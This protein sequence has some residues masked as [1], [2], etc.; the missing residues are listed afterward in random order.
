MSPDELFAAFENLFTA[1][2]REEAQDPDVVA[3]KSAICYRT[4]L[5]VDPAIARA[6]A[7]LSLSCLR[8]LKG[9]N[10]SVR[11]QHKSLNDWI[12][13]KTAQAAA[14]AEIP[15]MNANS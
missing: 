7:V 2:L 1:H 13:V 14:Q 9:P 12:V 3:F 10:D 4:G 8:A 5:A 11:V 6:D 15:G